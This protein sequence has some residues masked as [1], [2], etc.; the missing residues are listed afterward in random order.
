[1]HVNIND[2][3]CKEIS[4][5]VFERTL[6]RPENSMPGGLGAKHYTLTSGGQVYFNEQLT[7]YQHYVILGCAKMNGPHGDLLHQDSAWFLPCTSRWNDSEP[8][9][10]HSIVHG[11]E[12]EVRILTLTYK[13]PRPSF[14]WAKSR[15]HNLYK[16]PQYH[17]SKRIVGYAQLFKEEE[18]AVLG[19]L[20]MHALDIQTNTP[21]IE[22][23]DHKN[24][25][26][27]MYILRGKGLGVSE[28][29]EHQ[30]SAGSFLYTPEGGLH[31]IRS[32]DETIQYIVVEFVHH[33]KMWIERAYGK[34]GI[35]P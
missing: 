32:V 18:H 2:I 4:P 28:G 33:D 12:G 16:V 5:G 19:A 29:V 24:P 1:M 26:E 30:I 22:L 7:E 15:T 13:V 25:E 17:S 20:R 3:K 21:G 6:L 31:G 27:I 14:R 10:K 23:P 11:G 9:T 34:A 8:I 35:L